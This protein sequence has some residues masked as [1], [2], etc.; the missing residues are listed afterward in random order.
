MKP[1]IVVLLVVG[2]VGCQGA[3]EKQVQLQTHKD[4]VSYSIGMSVG[5]NLKKDSIAVVPD[6]FLRG[7]LDATAD[8][9][10]R[11]MTDRQVGETMATFREELQQKQMEHMRAAGMKNKTDGDAFLAENSKK[12]GVIVLPSGLQYRVITEGKG[13]KPIASSVVTTNYRGS[14]LDGTEFDSSYKRGQPATFPVGGVIKGWTEALQLMREGSKWELFI[15][16]SLAYGENGAGG[17]IPPN[18]TLIFEV[19]LLSIK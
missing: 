18:A 9:A 10:H 11:L 2:I 19:E 17:V 4:S 14:L 8:S 16:P 13:R 1:I 3:G 15:P 6:A 5:N 12:P 7:V